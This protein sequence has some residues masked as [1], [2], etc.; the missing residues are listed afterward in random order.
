MKIKD[1]YLS[2]LSEGKE[3]FFHIDPN[4]IGEIDDVNISREFNF[5][6]IDFTTTYGKPSSVVVNYDDFLKWYSQN[7]ES[8]NAF[9]DYISAF[10]GNSKES[11]PFLSTMN[12]IVDDNGNI[13]ASTDLPNNSTN[14]MVGSK[15]KWDLEKVY[16][17]SVP[18]GIRFYS[19]DLGIGIITW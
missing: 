10:V 16:K 6:K 17:Q 2:L 5:V 1:Y 4:S 13:M 11:E 19:G 7:K 3:N 14:T 18:K 15:L 8:K 12:E 9:K